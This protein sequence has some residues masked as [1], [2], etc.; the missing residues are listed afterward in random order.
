VTRLYLWKEGRHFPKLSKSSRFW[1]PGL[2]GWRGNV[3]IEFYNA[4]STFSFRPTH[5]LYE[6][7][8]LFPPYCLLHR[9]WLND[10]IINKKLDFYRNS[11]QHPNMLHPTKIGGKAEELPEWAKEQERENK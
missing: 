6:R 8:S 11:K 5:P 7:L 10:G 9:P 4:S 2:W 1:T 3:D